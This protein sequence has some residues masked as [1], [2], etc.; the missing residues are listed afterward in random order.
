[1]GGSSE[2]GQRAVHVRR[3]PPASRPRHCG[4]RALAAQILTDVAAGQGLLELAVTDADKGSALRGWP[5]SSAAV[6]TLYLGDD[7]TDRTPP[8]LGADDSPSDRRRR[9][10]ARTVSRHRVAGGLLELLADLLA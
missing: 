10:A 3:S 5:S 4:G 8:A 2:A 7:L 1:M 6:A 9:D